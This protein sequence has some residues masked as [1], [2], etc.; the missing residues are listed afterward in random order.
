MKESGQMKTKIRTIARSAEWM[1]DDA[2]VE[3]TELRGL[4]W[5]V[6]CKGMS[7]LR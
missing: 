3:F 2:H 6:P 1:S 5:A 4:R 7:A